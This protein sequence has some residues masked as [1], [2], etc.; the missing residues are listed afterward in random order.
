M[1]RKNR[2]IVELPRF[3]RSA[4]SVP[5][6][7]CCNQSIRVFSEV[8]SLTVPQTPG[9]TSTPTLVSSSPTTASTS[10]TSTPSSSVSRV[11]SVSPPSSS[12]T[13]PSA[14]PS[15]APS[16]SRLPTSRRCSRASKH[17][18]TTPRPPRRRRI[19]ISIRAENRSTVPL[20]PQSPHHH[21]H[22]NICPYNWHS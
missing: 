8:L 11:P 13:A 1:A 22:R 3:C 2:V 10:R 6:D 20:I 19:A 4:Q 9:P 5:H 17:L 21:P 16:R 18:A 7:L 14:C 15:S 12:G